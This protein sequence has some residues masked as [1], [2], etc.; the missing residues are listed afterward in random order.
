[1]TLIARGNDPTGHGYYGASRGVRKHEGFDL[2]TIAGE[3]VFAPHDGVVRIGNVYKKTKPNKPVM[4]LI[5]FKDHEYI[6]KIMYVKSDLRTGA[7]VKAGDFVGVAQNIT[8][9]HT[10]N[11]KDSDSEMLNHI[12]ISVWKNGLMT[13]PEPLLPWKI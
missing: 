2:V 3:N 5:E 6:T 8:S 4:K 11:E 10:E 1:M 13:D 7:F 9:Y 12:H